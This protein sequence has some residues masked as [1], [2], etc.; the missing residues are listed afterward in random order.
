MHLRG[1]DVFLNNN[2]LCK[3]MSEAETILFLIRKNRTSLTNFPESLS[4]NKQV[5]RKSII[6]NRL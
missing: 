2:D 5:N 1:G 4:Q 3:L 6:R